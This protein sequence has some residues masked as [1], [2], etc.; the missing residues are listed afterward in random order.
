MSRPMI[1]IFCHIL[2]EKYKKALYNKNLNTVKLQEMEGTNKTYPAL[3]DLQLRLK[4]L[5]R[6]EG[7]RQVLTILHPPEDIVNPA[8]AMELAKIANEEMAELVAKYPDHFIAGVA[9]LP[10]KN[11][12][13]ALREAE[14]AIKELNLKGAEIY[15]P[16]NGRPVDSPELFPLYEMMAK[17]DLPLWLHPYRPVNIPDYEGEKES[18]YNVFLS[19]GWPYETSVAM[20]RF[21]RS[22]VL[23]KY[24][25]LKIITHHLGG[26]APYYISRLRWRERLRGS[27]SPAIDLS[28][29]PEEYFKM[30]LC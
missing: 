1:D 6:F 22:G 26:M 9:C 25:S 8:G 28:R 24:P 30:F 14:R 3:S 16:C 15:T 12:D 11:I 29:P 19:I 4:L 27:S 20:V 2:P 7:M 5:S 18:R 13:A 23:E 17:F 21:V 10:T